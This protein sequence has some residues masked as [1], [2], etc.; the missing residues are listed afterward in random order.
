M[1]RVRAGA[2]YWLG[3]Q[4]LAS[5]KIER[6]GTSNNDK[7]VVPW[8]SCERD[9]SIIR[10][11]FRFTDGHP[12]TFDEISHLHAIGA[13]LPCC[14]MARRWSDSWLFHACFAFALL[15]LQAASSEPTLRLTDAGKSGIGPRDVG[16]RRSPGGVRVQHRAARCG[17]NCGHMIATRPSTQM[18]QMNKK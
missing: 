14:F 15:R 3:R 8:L 6:D 18:I 10:W 11:R 2:G 4:V 12:R 1:G 17:Q 5:D 16:M 13:A 7:W 9:A